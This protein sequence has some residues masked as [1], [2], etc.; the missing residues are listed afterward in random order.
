MLVASD[1]ALPHPSGVILASSEPPTPSPS[2]LLAWA[3]RGIWVSLRHTLS[4][5]SST[6]L[7]YRGCLIMA[8]EWIV[9]VKIL[10]VGSSHSVCTSSVLCP[11]SFQNGEKK[12]PS[13][14]KPPDARLGRPSE[15]QSLAAFGAGRETAAMA[16]SSCW[17]RTS[18]MGKLRP[19]V[20]EAGRVPGSGSLCPN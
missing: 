12:K 13:N 6:G 17:P 16:S 20:R 2:T 11:G 3:L 1:P 19:R 15:G 8:A 10:W 7:T 9:L 14:S 18:M 4:P 5:A